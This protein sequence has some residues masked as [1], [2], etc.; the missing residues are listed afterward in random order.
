MKQAPVGN[1]WSKH[2]TTEPLS[3]RGP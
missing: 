3:N 2:L 1:A